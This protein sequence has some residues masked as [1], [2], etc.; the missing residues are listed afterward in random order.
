MRVIVDA[1]GGDNAAV[2]ERNSHLVLIEGYFGEGNYRTVLMHGALVKKFLYYVAALNKV[3]LCHGF[4]VFGRHVGIES[5]FGINYHYRAE[6]AEAETA[7]FDY[8]NIAYPQLF[9]ALFK[10]FNYL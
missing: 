3:P 9:K 1:F 4:C 5:T 8:K 7:R 2:S 10:L 6:S